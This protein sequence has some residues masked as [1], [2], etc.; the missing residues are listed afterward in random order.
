MA[1]QVNM[2]ALVSTFAAFVQRYYVGFVAALGRFSD[3]QA[4]K[5][6]VIQLPSSKSIQHCR[7]SSH[8]IRMLATTTS[9]AYVISSR[10][11][12]RRHRLSTK[13]S[14]TDQGSLVLEWGCF[15][16]GVG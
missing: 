16:S 14:L 4:R 10:R 2:S 1:V 11:R 13:P 7:Y 9:N 15:G 5:E 12:P 3:S 8:R 6:C